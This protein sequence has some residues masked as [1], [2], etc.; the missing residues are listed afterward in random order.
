MN[1]FFDYLDELSVFI[2]R[3]FAAFACFVKVHLEHLCH[4][5]GPKYFLC[6]CLEG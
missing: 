6:L 1:S 3:C 2:G 4:L 5:S